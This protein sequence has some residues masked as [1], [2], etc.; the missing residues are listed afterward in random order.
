MYTIVT[1]PSIFATFEVIP[2]QEAVSAALCTKLDDPESLL[3]C[4]MYDTM[5]GK[6][7]LW[8]IRREN[9]PV[10]MLLYAYRPIARQ[11]K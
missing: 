7:R 2:V 9:H 6:Q 10:Q 1:Q 3:L 4:I 8:Q 5:R 11:K